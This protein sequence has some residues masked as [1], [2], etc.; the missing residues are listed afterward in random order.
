MIDAGAE[1]NGATNT[2]LPTEDARELAGVPDGFG[3]FWTPY[4]MA[5]IRGEGKPADAS[6]VGCPFCTAPGKDDQAGL[7]V[8]RGDACFVLMN[9]FPYNSGHLLVCPYRQATACGE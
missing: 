4:R 9:L 8:Y 6:D 2:Q 5:Y 3:R 1:S 7:I